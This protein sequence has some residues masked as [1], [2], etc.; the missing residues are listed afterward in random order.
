MAKFLNE[1]PFNGPS[2]L[3]G[4]FTFSSS[5]PIAVIALRGLTNERGEFLITT[6]PV[7]DLRSAAATGAI[8]FPH[9][10]DGGGWTTQIVLVNPTDTVLPGTI[11]FVDSSGRPADVAVN[12][13]YS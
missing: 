5:I 7:T 4:A 1:P 6:L 9:F 10:A 2:S 11:Q 3:S 12:S 8:V 13:V